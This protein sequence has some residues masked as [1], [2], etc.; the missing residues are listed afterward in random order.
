MVEK[1]ALNFDSVV[2]TTNNSLN[3]VLDRYIIIRYTAGGESYFI[4][5]D[6]ASRRYGKLKVAGEVYTSLKDLYFFGRNEGDVG[7]R[8]SFNVYDTSYTFNGALLLGK[9]QY[10]R[11]RMIQLEEIEI[12]GPQNTA[13]VSSPNFSVSVLPSQDGRNFDP[14]LNLSAASIFGGLAT[15]NLHH[16]A[17]NH[18]VLIKGAFSVNTLQ[19]KFVPGGER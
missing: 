6:T 8:L 12:E 1:L 18:S 9:F 11:S 10:V 16:T 5:F 7:Y 4:V 19:L 15:Y 2:F 3:Y 13:V 17:R 14:A